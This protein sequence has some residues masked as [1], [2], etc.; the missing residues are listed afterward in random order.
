MYIQEVDIYSSVNACNFPH[1]KQGHVGSLDVSFCIRKDV[2][3]IMVVFFATSHSLLG[4]KSH[5]LGR[6][7]KAVLGSAVGM[8]PVDKGRCLLWVM[9]ENYGLPLS[10]ICY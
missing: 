3:S 10:W 6:K 4:F 9:G 5:P 8:N 2:K 1:T 7:K